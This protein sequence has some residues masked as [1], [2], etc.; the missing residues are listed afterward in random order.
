M[1]Q[2]VT[3]EVSRWREDGHDVLIE[4]GEGFILAALTGEFPD[5]G[6][7]V[8]VE[9]GL[10]DGFGGFDLVGTQDDM[11]EGG[12]EVAD[13]VEDGS[14]LGSGFGHSIFRYQVMKSLLSTKGTNR[15]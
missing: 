6:F 3:M 2:A 1:G 9:D 7:A 12:G 11:A 15:H 13:M 5:E 8:V 4:G 10:D 14:D